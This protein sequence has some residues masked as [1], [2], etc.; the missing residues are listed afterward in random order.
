MSGP[1]GYPAQAG[2]AY[3]KLKDSTIVP[4]AAGT[5]KEWEIPKGSSAIRIQPDDDTLS[6]RY[7]FTTGIVS[8]TEGTRVGPGGYLN[9]PGPYHEGQSIFIAYETGSG[10]KTFRVTYEDLV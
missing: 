3:A 9:L 6:W 10:S 7:A 4:T 1:D 2:H 5:E 8:A